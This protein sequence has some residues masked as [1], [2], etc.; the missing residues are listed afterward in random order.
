M[1]QEIPP[2]SYTPD[3][4]V[5]TCHSIMTAEVMIFSQYASLDTM[6]VSCDASDL[7]TNASMLHGREHRKYRILREHESEQ[8]ETMRSAIERNW[9]Y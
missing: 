6:T 1:W 7:W 3:G 5:E 8:R 9:S 2:S 4:S